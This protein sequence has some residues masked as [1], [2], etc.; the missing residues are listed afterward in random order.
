MKI[1][2]SAFACA[3]NEGSE[4]EIG[5]QWAVGTDRMGHDVLVRTTADSK[6]QIEREINQRGIP[7]NLSFDMFMPPLLQKVQDIGIGVGLEGVTY[8]FVHLIWQLAALRH[9]RR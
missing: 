4:S 8:H 2:M 9:V 6:Q 5:W 1:L 7:Q 3:P